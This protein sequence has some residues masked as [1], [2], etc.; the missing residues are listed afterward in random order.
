MSSI[1]VTLLNKK[2]GFIMLEFRQEMKRLFSTD[3]Y[4]QE[5]TFLLQVDGSMC[6]LCNFLESSLSVTRLMF[7]E[8]S[9]M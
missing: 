5:P 8:G 6:Y 1:L 7:K 4:A 9:W 3:N 2:G